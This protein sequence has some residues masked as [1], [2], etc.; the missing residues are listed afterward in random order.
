MV[1]T[2]QNKNKQENNPQSLVAIS[3]LG[4]LMQ[5]ALQGEVCTVLPAAALNRLGFCHL[6]QPLQRSAGNPVSTIGLRL[7]PSSWS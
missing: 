6:N 3:I 7:S 2:K 1:K 5:T 4:F